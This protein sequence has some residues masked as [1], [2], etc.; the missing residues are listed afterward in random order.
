MSALKRPVVVLV[1]GLV[2]AGTVACSG[3]GGG[4]PTTKARLEITAPTPI[5]TTGADVT[6]K[7]DLIG[8]KVV[9]PTQVKGALNGTEGHIH[10]S[11]DG[12]LVSMNYGLDAPITGLKPGAHNV[13]AEFVAVDHQPFKNKVVAFVL[14]QVSS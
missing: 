7:M 3:K 9:P 10:V 11:V 4:R 14:F 12:Q 13:E 8:A 2:M 5:A 1:L 6:L